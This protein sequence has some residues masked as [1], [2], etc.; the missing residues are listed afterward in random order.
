LSRAHRERCR[1]LPGMSALCKGAL[2]VQGGRSLRCLQPVGLCK[3]TRAAVQLGA[4]PAQLGG[5]RH[6]AGAAASKVIKTVDAEIKHE[7]DQYEQAKEIKSFVSGS[8]FKLVDTAGDVNMALERDM[9]DKVVR[10]EW[11]LTSP[12]DPDADAE[13]ENQGY[14]QEATD[15]CVTVESKSAG[16]GMTFY[17]STQTGEDHRYVIGNVKN[18]A[19]AEEK[20]S[21]TSYNGPEFED[22]DEKLQEAL[23]EYLSEVGMNNQVCDFIDAVALDK[24][25]R[26]YIRWLK[27][28]K[29]FLES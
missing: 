12:F 17:C 16:C 13:G 15:F 24:E 1:R 25:Q 6:F 11:Q 22:V 29:S 21:I 7:E 5:A 28:T 20:D 19:S 14:E 3:A 23:D 4:R 27:T 2:R 10:I 9:G 8:E 26:E 18:F